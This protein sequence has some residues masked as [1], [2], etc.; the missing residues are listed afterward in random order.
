MKYL[1]VVAMSLLLASSPCLGYSGE[2]ECT[3]Y[4][5]PATGIRPPIRDMAD[6]CF[7]QEIPDT[8]VL[9]VLFLDGGK[10][11]YQKKA[12]VGRSCFRIGL[13]WIDPKNTE[14]LLLC[15]GASHA[16]LSHEIV[17]LMHTRR[18]MRID[19]QACLG[20]K[21]YCRRTWVEN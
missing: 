8:V 3:A 11:E 1:E 17:G 18:G 6:I 2:D 14:S 21:N 15:N 12:G 7:K 9:S 4:C 10:R 20:N 19:Q 5:G 16:T 13:H